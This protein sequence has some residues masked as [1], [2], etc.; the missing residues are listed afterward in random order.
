MGHVRYDFLPYFLRIYRPGQSLR[1]ATTKGTLGQRKIRMHQ[2]VDGSSSSG[3]APHD[4]ENSNIFEN[5]SQYPSNVVVLRCTPLLQSWMTTIRDSRTDGHTFH[6]AVEQVSRM[7]LF[8]GISFNKPSTF[9]Q[10]QAWQYQR[11]ANSHNRTQ[12]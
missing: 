12:R 3:T 4:Q 9:F 7:I 1:R 6:K 11:L 5:G 8:E 10:L 2:E